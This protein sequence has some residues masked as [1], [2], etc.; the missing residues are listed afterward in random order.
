[1]SA[2]RSATAAASIWK[3]AGDVMRLGGQSAKKQRKKQ[4]QKQVLPFSPVSAM[5]AP[6]ALVGTSRR[7][8]TLWARGGRRRW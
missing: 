7:L 2:S 1:M 6:T 8:A 3:R 4:K 5:P